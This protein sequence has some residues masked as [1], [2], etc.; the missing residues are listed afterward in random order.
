MGGGVGG[1]GEGGGGECEEADQ[2]ERTTYPADQQL[3]SSLTLPTEGRQAG[4]Q[5]VSYSGSRSSSQL[6]I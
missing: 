3:C 4:I 5:V 1:G 2:R 6:V